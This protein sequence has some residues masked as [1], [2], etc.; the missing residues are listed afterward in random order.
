[1]QRSVQILAELT[2]F[3]VVFVTLLQTVEKLINIVRY[4]GVALVLAGWGLSLYFLFQPGDE[5]L[6]LPLE[7]IIA[8]WVSAPFF[9][10]LM[11]EKKTAIWPPQ[12]RLRLYALMEALSI[13]SAIAYSG[14]IGIESKPPLTLFILVPALSIGLIT[15]VYMALR[16]MKSPEN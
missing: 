7:V 10:L 1:M 13:L 3:P 11:I 4:F 16:K 5:V 8:A 2:L 6:S 14:L 12:A 9:S 15:I